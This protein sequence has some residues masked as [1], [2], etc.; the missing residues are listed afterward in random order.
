MPDYERDLTKLFL[1]ETWN[2]SNAPFAFDNPEKDGVS[3]V[4]LKISPERGRKILTR[5]SPTEGWRRL[6]EFLWAVPKRWFKANPDGL[7]HR[8]SN[9][10]WAHDVLD[11]KDS[12]PRAVA[13]S[14]E[15]LSMLSIDEPFGLRLLIPSWRGAMIV[16]FGWPEVFGYVH[17]E[18]EAGFAIVHG[19]NA[20]QGLILDGGFRHRDDSRSKRATERFKD[21][22]SDPK[23][24]SAVVGQYQ[25]R[26]EQD[27][28][29]ELARW[30]ECEKPVLPR[31]K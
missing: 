7:A 21:H 1:R 8:V 19:R 5:M 18:G 16:A 13:G 20:A 26:R 12:G 27:V 29:K 31:P 14:E 28:A 11:D 6:P 24:Y 3:L 2:A 30:E 4:G 22:S 9:L 15:A 23:H 25:A 10:L 17:E